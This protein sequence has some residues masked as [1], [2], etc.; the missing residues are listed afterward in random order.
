MLVL[1][2][3]HADNSANRQSLLTAYHAATADVALQVGDLLHYELPMET[4]FVAG[5]NEDFDVIDALRRGDATL[6]DATRPHLLASTVVEIDGLRVGGLSGNYAPTQYEK[7]RSDLTGGRRRHF[8][9]EDVERAM[10]LE[11]VDIFLAHE[12]PYGLLQSGGRDVGSEHVGALIEEL[13]PALCFV[14]H[15]H[16]HAEGMFRGTRVM[17]LA[18]V[19]ESYYTLDPATLDVKRHETSTEEPST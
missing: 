14:G 4:Y 7:S 19:W 6:T 5:N 18:P 11:D 2:D 10:A 3:A 8:T 13:S 16:R 17:S 12:P 15:H 9:H 1:G